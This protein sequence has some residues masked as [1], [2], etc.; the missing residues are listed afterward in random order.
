MKYF[1]Y[2]VIG[3][4]VFWT[5]EILSVNIGSAIGLGPGEIGLVVSAI[6]LLC[7]IIV[8]CTIIIVKAIKNNNHAK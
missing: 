4:L 8:I 3:F 7:A 2:F 6:S 1:G 5:V